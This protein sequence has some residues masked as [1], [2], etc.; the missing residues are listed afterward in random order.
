MSRQARASA[1]GGR[2]GGR[3]AAIAALLLTLGSACSR[4]AAPPTLTAI[5]PDRGP[6]DRPVDVVIT[7]ERLRPHLFTDFSKKSGSTLSGAWSARLGRVALEQVALAEDGLHAVV[8]AGLTPGLYTLHVVTPSNLELTLAD[9][10]R[11]VSV[12]NLDALVAAY[13][14]EPV[15]PQ[16]VGVPFDVTVTAR[17]EQGRVVD[18]FA[19]VASLADRTGTVV[20]RTV[21]PF[22]SGTWTGRVEVRAPST[23][24]ALTVSDAA[25]RTGASNDFPVGPGPG[26]ALR[27]QTPPRTTVAGGCSEA[28]TLEAVDATGARVTL[29]AALALDVTATPPTGLTLF[30]D[31]ACTTALTALELAT[32]GAA[33]VYL[34]STRAGQ[35]RLN[36]S[37]A[38][39]VG[40]A[41]V[42]TVTPAAP[43]SFVFV[44]P[45]P[46]VT[47][48]ACSNTVT[49]AVRDAF[50]NDAPGT[51]ARL[52][53]LS[54]SPS[55][56]FTFFDAPGCG[57]AATQVT[58]PAGSARV[59][60]SLQGTTA[61]VV[62]VTAATAGLPDA[63]QQVRITPEGFP[64]RVVIVSPP[65]TLE[66]GLCSGPL[67]AQTQDS[68]G[69]AVSSPTPVTLALDSAPAG[70][71]AFFSDDTCMTPATQVIVAGGTSTALVYFRGVQPGAITAQVSSTGLMGDA[72]VQTILPGP[73]AQL[74]FATPP[75]SA[76]AGSCSADV[77][78]E[79]R[80]AMGFSTTVTAP[81]VVSLAATPA[82]GFTFF[83]DAACTN[84]VTSATLA[85]GT[86]SARL[87]FRGSAAGQVTVDGQSPGLTPAQQVETVTPA[88]PA[89]LVFLTAAQTVGAGMCSGVATVE[90]RD[91]FGNAAPDTAARVLAL[92][93]AP[94]TGVTFFADPGCTTASSN[95][96]LPAG[97]TQASFFFR[98]TQVGTLTL[99]AASAG[100]T[101]AQQQATV[102]PG[103][104]AAL[105]FT[106]A[107]QS[108]TAGSCSGIATVQVRDSL[109][110]ASPVASATSVGLVAAPAAGF[111]FFSDA[112]CTT[113][114]SAVSVPAGG[115][116]ASFYFRGTAAGLVAVTAS[117]TG[118]ASA[119]QSETITP[120]AAAALAF[121]TPARTVTAGGCSA[122][123]D[124]QVRDGFGNA[125]PQ[126]A[127]RTVNLSAM[128]S[129]GFTF[130]SDAACGTAATSVTIGAGASTV[131]FYVRGTSAGS[132]TVTAQSAGVTDAT[133]AVTVTA[134]ATP[135]KLAFTTPTRTVVAGQCS[136]V[137]SVQS[138]DSFDNPRAVAANTAVSLSAVPPTGVT[139]FS[140]AACTT[141]A[142][143]VTLLAGTDSVSF[144][145]RGGS[146]GATQVTATAAG[147][148][149]ATQAV[150]V[151]AAPPDRL[152]FVT[153]ARTVAAGSCS[154][155]LTV[156][157]RDALGNASP[158]GSATTVNLTSGPG[159]TFYS[160]AACGTAVT[161]VTL[162]AAATQQSFYVRGTQA[163]SPTVTAT[164]AGLTPATQGLT[165][166]AGAPTKLAFTN[167]ALSTVAGG[168]SAAAT[169]QVRDTYDNAVTLA[170]PLPV[171]LTTS[172][173]PV[174][175]YTGACGTAV[176]QVTVAAGSS[177]ASF[178][179]RGTTAGAVT[180]TATATG[181]T[182][183]AQ[184]ETVTPAAPAQLV[185]IT[186]PQT[187]TA[188]SCSAVA[189]LEARDAYGNASPV[190]A[191]T[192]VN[193][194]ATPATGF[195]FF[196]AAGCG[197]GTASVTL[198]AGASQV[199]FFFRGTA[200][201]A[202]QA[203]GSATGFTAANQTETI[204]PGPATTF[205][206]DP[207]SSPRTLGVPFA[208]TVR[209]RDAFG[210]A[211]TSFAGTATLSLTPVATTVTCVAPCT[212]ASVT[213]VF[214]AGVWSGT[215]TLGGSSGTGR[216]LTATQGVISGS[217]AA[218]DVVVANR[219]PPIARFTVTPRVV[220]TG[221]N[222]S[223]DA[224]TSSDLQ[225]ATA[226]LQ[227]S[228][229][230]TGSA[231]GPPPWSAWTTTK[232]A[233][234]SFATAGLRTVRL[235]VR[236]A[237][238]DIGYATGWVQVLSGA[239]NRCIVDT[240]S[241]T[242]DGA[243]S[244]SSRGPD[245][246]LSLV[247][248]VRLSNSM[249]GVQTI[250]FD[251]ARTITGSGFGTLNFTS[252]ADVI[253][254]SGVQLVGWVPRVTQAGATVRM[255]GLELSGQNV[256]IT[257]AAGAT[258]ELYDTYL[259][260]LD[261]IV[262]DG[263]LLLDK[264][265]MASCTNNACVAVR[266]ATTVRYSHFRASGTGIDVDGC[267]AGANLLN[268]FASVFSGLSWG[269]N[270]NCPS[271]LT[272]RHN[273]F[274]SNGVG[275]DFNSPG[276]TG[277]VLVNNLFTNHTTAALT[278]CPNATFTTRSHHVLFGNA[279][280]EA[281]SG[282]AAGACCCNI[283]SD[284]SV[285]T[286]NPLY[287]LP[288]SNDYRL[289]FGSPSID[290]ALDLGLP[291]LPGAPANFAGA[292]AD[293]GGR[294]SY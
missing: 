67:A 162:G 77:V 282:G 239:T 189:T 266:A 40:A 93:A 274:D 255:Y 65:Q 35:V 262:T 253:A 119:Q 125:V 185:F 288:A 176:T 127:A 215:I 100:L 261:G 120:A 241:N 18:G 108:R 107:A 186:A 290:S 172:G 268:V 143:S 4:P 46:T 243:S 9:A 57:T 68:L 27:F 248:A 209:A 51:A 121:L 166:N 188:G 205:A 289:T 26:A 197:T 58:M 129:A 61:G 223:F 285:L 279:A 163:G 177:T 126:G 85:G 44:T 38:G 104:A 99:T 114:V 219:T 13:R 30:A 271:S 148:N 216:V 37:A 265:T 142:A 47:A 72:Q 193:L 122:N 139:F 154:A 192:T 74:A 36:A 82:P 180:V 102:T 238:G 32:N 181:L 200:S 150:T 210:N 105:A 63:T 94:S 207:I 291:L 263:T 167:T 138:R 242:D 187:L 146:A 272:L 250:T 278:D 16:R 50:G 22:L 228:W 1:P 75:R 141:P 87:Y 231:G 198:G 83:D 98:A 17:D 7:G 168:C 204:N 123:L 86:G 256:D 45:P 12:D 226:A 31:A 157:S 52:V 97:S 179:L 161:Q 225:T 190:G 24:D 202:V 196:T 149:P 217:S 220:T 257:V 34:R 92:S 267:S 246:R 156:E 79:V 73:A 111:T 80:D 258:L 236:D 21:G 20:P 175:L 280:N 15:A 237:D 164:A 222:V 294:E 112:S 70:A 84:A 54:A 116:T 135:S 232:T 170:S 194:S 28:V 101:S 14:I 117:A 69:N 153:P 173:V 109:G 118:L 53:A 151:N 2:A 233:T 134:A 183:A 244:C 171:N 160:D 286:S 130:Y 212:S 29:P 227:V 273:T 201:G 71:L 259:H 269:I 48:G 8:P 3:W 264:V 184:V 110:N 6:A 254:P 64:S 158:P 33:T 165:V 106:T 19:G 169:V 62:T 234:N 276:G 260:N 23:A 41:Q 159:V 128:P 145:V 270:G 287:A 66:V 211:A 140:D 199:S 10:F 124:V 96:T 25:G 191:A 213:D 277:H 42:E 230:F 224:S 218:F 11:V 182:P 88:P 178:T 137:L 89:Q 245:N 91:A 60:L 95:V 76:P 55:A 283:G 59:D 144:Y 43:T 174:T 221:E 206:W 252:T 5:T 247:E 133:Q 208:V 240:S 214:A 113:A 284:P 203:T 249:A 131:S 103:A 49:L 90:A 81:A 229:D 115:A 39:L 136:A 281:S 293:R 56:G 235:A 251:Q 152:V 195:G 78:I 275:I 132:V 147:L 155:V 292:G